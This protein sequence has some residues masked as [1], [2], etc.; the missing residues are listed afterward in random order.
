MMCM[1]HYSFIYYELRVVT[2]F[3]TACVR[4]L[5]SSVAAHFELQY[6]YPYFYYPVVSDPYKASQCHKDF[7]QINDIPKGVFSLC[8]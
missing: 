2:S 5:F 8:T 7:Y 3:G 1:C 6:M 4:T